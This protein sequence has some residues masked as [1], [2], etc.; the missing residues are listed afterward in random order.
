MIKQ[1]AI[2]TMYHL[3]IMK[4][5][6]IFLDMPQNKHKY[7]HTSTSILTHSI[8]VTEVNRLTI[9]WRE[10]QITWIPWVD[11]GQLVS[12]HKCITNGED[13]WEYLRVLG[14]PVTQDIQDTICGC[15][16]YYELFVTHAFRIVKSCEAKTHTRIKKSTEVPNQVLQIPC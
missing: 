14:D 2:V 9:F 4:D 7:P 11:W 8:N 10:N 1:S 6:C 15:S 16:A 12:F 3:S 13:E 5:R